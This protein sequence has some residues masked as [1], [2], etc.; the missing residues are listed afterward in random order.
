MNPAL[1]RSAA[2]VIVG[3]VD[4]P[5]P[6]DD[7]A[8]HLFRVLRLRDGEVVTVTDGRGAWRA[9]RVAGGVLAPADDVVRE[10]AP[11]PAVVA[12]AVPKGD[13]LEWM[14]QKLT[15]LGATEIVLVHCARSVVRWDAA[16]A[17]KQLVRLERVVR[18]AACQSRRVWLPSVTGPVPFAEVVGRPGM[19]LADPEGSAPVTAAVGGVLVGPEGGFTDE[20][21]AAAAHRVRLTDTVLRVETAALAA[22]CAMTVLRGDPHGA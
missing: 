15:E 8:H 10:P 3:S 4:H 5:Q 2:H 21:V 20:E 16:R 11:R 12:T 17:A 1:R 7:D 19:A 9:T 14:V 6:S 18:E 22:L 13:R